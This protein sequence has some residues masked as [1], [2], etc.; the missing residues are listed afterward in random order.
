MPNRELDLTLIPEGLRDL[1]ERDV[2]E[3]DAIGLVHKAGGA[4]LAFVF[5]NRLV[6]IDLGMFERALVTAFTACRMNN[7][8]WHATDIERLFN[9]CDREKLWAVGTEP[10]P[11]DRWV[12][13]RGVAGSR[14]QRKV[15]GL[16][17]TS[18]RD[19]ACWWAT[20]FGLPDPAV[21]SATVA[22]QEVYCYTDDRREA[23]FICR[24][25]RCSRV[26]LSADDIRLGAKRES[27]RRDRVDALRLQALR[28]CRGA[29]VALAIR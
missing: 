15:R 2:E 3:R 22:R 17:W 4:A 1:V 12:V 18:S 24:P 29:T 21:Y 11:G 8:V 25:K 26:D 20:R 5:D 19:Q 27:D 6:L 14:G 28:D 9:K 7:H 10:P 13:Y 16:S 23:E